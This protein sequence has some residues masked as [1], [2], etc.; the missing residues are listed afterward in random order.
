MTRR[1]EFKSLV[2]YHTYRLANT[3]TRKAITAI[4]TGK[5]NGYLKNSRHH[6]EYKFSGDPAIQILDFLA[7][8]K[9]AADLNG[10]SEGVATLIQP[11]F[12]QGRAKAGLNSRL[13]QIV[14]LIPKYPAA[15]QFLL[16]SYATEAVI[17]AGCQKVFTAKQLPEEDE[18]TF[19]NRLTRNATET[20]SVQGGCPHFDICRCTP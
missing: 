7:I 16:Q 9:D 15:V 5:A 2:S 11:Y 13:K 14:A 18:K 20:G 10:V 8:L 3:N 6:L 17:A 19:A 4:G 12:L 1:P